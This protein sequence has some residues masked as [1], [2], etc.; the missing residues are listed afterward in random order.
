MLN[1]AVTDVLEDTVPGSGHSSDE[2]YFHCAE[3]NKVCTSVL[4]SPIMPSD[5]S[6][7]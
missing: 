6:C 3:M 4:L 7:H 1:S 5:L 2:G